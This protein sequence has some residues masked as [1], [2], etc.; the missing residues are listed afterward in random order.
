MLNWGFIGAGLAARAAMAPA[1]HQSRLG[2]LRIAA[3]RDLRRAEALSPQKQSTDYED[4]LADD[5]VDVVYISLSNESHLAWCV[6]ALEAGKH[7]LC[8]KPLALSAAQVDRIAEAAD[9]AG[10]T[11]SEAMW[12]RWH[13]R[14]RSAERIAASFGPGAHTEATFAVHRTD[15]ANY[16]W[17]PARGGGA[18]Y[19][20]GG[21]VL[22]AVLALNG[23]RA[24][25]IVSSAMTTGP[26]GVDTST[27]ASLAWDN[28]ATAE[29]HVSF[30]AERP[31]EVLDL[32]GAG[33]QL[34]L[35]DW[36]FS[37]VARDTVHLV[38]RDR[39]GRKAV[40]EYSDVNSYRLMVDEFNRVV[41]GEDGRHGESGELV[42][43]AWTMPLAESRAVAALSEAVAREAS[44]KEN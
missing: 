28:G 32:R 3:A 41:S 10:R 1:V 36:P 4:V 38:H 34:S 6:K 43:R 33:E 35:P 42:E 14:M 20:L 25:R 17:D 8:E 9:R 39:S 13:P 37:A 19:D 11:V 40:T 21:Y 22:S 29:V 24:P 16:R 27:T 26:T 5:A 15:H 30:T 12:Y 7:V 31:R 2:A 23:W 44:S 18:L